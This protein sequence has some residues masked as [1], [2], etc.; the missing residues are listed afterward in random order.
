MAEAEINAR[1][2]AGGGV[3]QMMGVGGRRSGIYVYP[4]TLGSKGA[5]NQGRGSEPEGEAN[6]MKYLLCGIRNSSIPGSMQYTYLNQSVSLPIP[7]EGLSAS[8]PQNWGPK[9]VNQIAMG[10]IAGGSKLMDLA[11]GEGGKLSQLM[12]RNTQTM[13]MVEA[14]LA[15]EAGKYGGPD[16]MNQPSNAQLLNSAGRRSA[17]MQR[18]VG[19]VTGGATA[20]SFN[21]G[22][23]NNVM[24]GAMTLP[25]LSGL[26]ENSQYN[27]GLRS[28]DQ[29]MMSY[30][31]PGFRSFNFN[32]RFRPQ[33]P[34]EMSMIESIV[35]WFKYYSAPTKWSNEITRVYELPAVFKIKFYTGFAE[36]THMNKIGYCALDNIQVKYGG[37]KFQTFVPDNQGAPP[38]ETTIQLSF[39]ELEIVVR[40]V[41]DARDTDPTVQGGY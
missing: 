25:G 23:A 1:S 31:G 33:S 3:D 20:N 26:A 6:Y 16:A 4:L 22:F 34:E 28:I 10:A 37:N 36:N 29:Q 32:Y 38:V 12:A 24:G 14:W 19:T 27:L 11:G 8:Y 35:K 13:G 2:G 30:G 15:G 40:D 21:A 7:M 18:V 39:K 5:P 9:G 41:K 17:L